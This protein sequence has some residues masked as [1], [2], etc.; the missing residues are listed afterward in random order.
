MAN[1]GQ[2]DQSGGFHHPEVIC[3]RNTCQHV[4]GMIRGEKG[5]QNCM[6][7]L[8]AVMLRMMRKEKI[9]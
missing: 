8:I 9:K 4:Q 3:S 2:W 6:C 7:T 5:I 1:S